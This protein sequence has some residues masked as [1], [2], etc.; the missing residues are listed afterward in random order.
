MKISAEVAAPLEL[1]QHG[2]DL[3]PHGGVEHRDRLVADQPVGLEHERGGDRHPLALAAGELVRVALRKRSGSRP[4]SSSAR[5]TRSACSSRGTP[6][7]TQRLGDDRRAPA[8]AGS[9]SGRGPGRSSARRRRSSPRPALPFDRLRRRAPRAGGRLATSPSIAR[10]SVDL[11][12]PGLADHAEDLA[13]PPLQRDAVE[14]AR[15]AAAGAEPDREVADLHQRPSLIGRLRDVAGAARPATRSRARS[16]TPR[17]ARARPR[18]AAGRRGSVGGVRA[19]RAEAAALAAARPDRAGRPG[20]ARRARAARRSPAASRAGA[21]C[22]GAGGRR[23]RELTGPVSTIRPAYMIAIRSQVSASTPEVVGDQDQRQAELLAQPLEQLQ[24]L[25]LHDH[26]E[27][28]RRL[29]GDHQRRAAGEREGDHHPL[30]LPAGELVRV[31]APE[32][33]ASARPSSSSSPIRSR[34]SPR[35]RPRSCRRIASAIWASTR[36]T[37]S[38][39]FIAPW[40]T[41]E[42]WRQRTQPHAGLGAPADVDRLLHAR[43]GAA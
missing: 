9:A 33:S 26:V 7:T 12:Q 23:T 19:A 22:R 16:G 30:A 4:T 24:D 18:A 1:Q 25:R 41:S 36:C 10:A 13:A 39:E 38:S 34:T 27:R 31:A 43:A 2:E 21:S 28:R 20:S 11:P 17:L 8:G 14:R 37:G 42:T 40:K 35:A 5:R 15:D 32:R 6:W 29:V 3:R